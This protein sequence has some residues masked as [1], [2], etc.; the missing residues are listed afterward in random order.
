MRSIQRRTLL[1]LLL[2]SVTTVSA[3]GGQERIRL[4][5]PPAADVQ[6]AVEPKP[7]PTEEI[8]TSAQASEDYN[9]SVEAWGDRVSA[10][11]GRICRWIT[12]AG[13]KLPFKCPARPAN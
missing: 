6:A 9:A 12:D 3:C 4:G 13:G 2:L 11:G 5:F 8:L 7:Q 1:P 10:A